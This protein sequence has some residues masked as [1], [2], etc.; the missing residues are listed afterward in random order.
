MDYTDW[1]IL[2]TLAKEKKITSTAEKLFITQPALT[3][4][5]KMLEQEFHTPLIVRTSRGIEFT[6]EG[7]I[8]CAYADE[9]LKKYN[10][11][12]N[13]VSSMDEEI[14]GVV[15][16]AVSPAFIREMIPDIL[17]EFRKKYPLIS[18]YLKTDLSSI[19]IDKLMK[20]EV[21]V[22][23][24]RGNYNLRCNSHLLNV[25]PITLVAKEKINLKDLPK[26]PYIMYETDESLER[27]VFTWWYDNYDT[28][29]NI[30]MHINDS[31]ACREMVKRNLGFSILP[32]TNNKENYDFYEIGLLKKDG[33]Y[34]ERA[35]WIIYKD[36]TKKINATKVFIDF[37]RKY[38]ADNNNLLNKI[39]G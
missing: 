8:V 30:I 14:R 27:D 18:I 5:I 9:M 23:I 33:S 6:S 16:V 25:R 10:D 17:C 4:R 29:P 1:V 26:L 35:S 34:L 36:Y 19:C 3:Y 22:A 31:S 11:V 20:D 38:M 28:P 21:Q 32:A 7:S 39:I 12:M 2:K 15:S 13:V 37:V 24:I